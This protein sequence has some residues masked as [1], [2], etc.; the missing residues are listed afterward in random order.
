MSHYENENI[1]RFLRVFSLWRDTT[2]GKKGS[3]IKETEFVVDVFKKLSTNV[4]N[5]IDLGGGVGTH[6]IPLTW[7]MNSM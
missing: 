7:R 4:N 2:L 1:R 6:A 3:E 5:I